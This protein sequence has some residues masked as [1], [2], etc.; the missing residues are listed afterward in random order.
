MN[1]LER[2]IHELYNNYLKHPKKVKDLTNLEKL[3]FQYTND[4]HI[5]EKEIINETEKV[6]DHCHLTGTYNGPA[7]SK[8]NLNY[9]LPKFVPVILHNLRHY[10]SYLFIKNLCE[11]KKQ[12]SVIAQN[13]EKYISFEKF[14]V[15]DSYRS[16]D[17]DQLNENILILDLLIRV[18]SYLILCLIW[19][20]LLIILN[21][22]R[23]PNIIQ[24]LKNSTIFD[25]KGFS[26]ISMLIVIP[27]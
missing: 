18:C 13:K 21:A 17:K 14:I 5:C 15:V 12:L 6:L 8:C 11:N 24:H 3:D 22:Y 16:K 4:C 9:Q 26:H 25:K 10:D 20:V 1:Y 23:Y 2:D 27:N 7:H 19:R